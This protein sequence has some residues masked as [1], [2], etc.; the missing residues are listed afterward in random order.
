METEQ[1]ATKE[2]TARSQARDSETASRILL[3]AAP[4]AARCEPGGLQRAALG[5]AWRRI[6]DA[7]SESRACDRAVDSFVAACSVSISR[8]T[9]QCRR[10]K[11]IHVRCF[12]RITLAGDSVGIAKT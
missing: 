11:T 7:V 4:S 3:Q 2:S 12:V 10:A 9:W 8:S 5:A 6:R 1:A